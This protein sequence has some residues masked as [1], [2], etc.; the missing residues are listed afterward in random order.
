MF[1]GSRTRP[2]ATDLKGHRK[3]TCQ[4]LGL[5]TVVRSVG[6]FGASMLAAGKTLW[7][8]LRLGGAMSEAV[9]VDAVRTPNASATKWI[10]DF[11]EGSRD[12]RELLGGKGSGIAEMTRVLGSDLVP[13]GFTI[14][15]EACVEYMRASRVP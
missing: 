7:R 14:T 1:C 6:R 9:I 2:R 10:Y 12:M 4:E 13:A 5:C 3:P 8:L 15:T 11:A